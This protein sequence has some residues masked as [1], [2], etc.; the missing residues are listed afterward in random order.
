MA[1]YDLTKNIPSASSLKMGDIL[2]CPYSGTYQTLVL[3]KGVYIVE[4]WGA[5]GGSTSNGAGG[6]GAYKGGVLPLTQSSTTLYLYV[7]GAGTASSELGVQAGGWNGGGAGGYYYGGSGGGASDIRIN[8]TSLYAR[9]IVAGGGGGGCSYSSSYTGGYGGGSAAAGDGAGYSTTYNAKGAT[10]TAGGAG[11]SYNGGNYIGTAGSFG[12]GGAAATST[13]AN[14]GRSGGGGGG[15]YGG[16][17]GG[18]RAATTYYYG[19][20]GG[21]GGSSYAYNSSNASNY[22]SG[23]LLDSNYY[24]GQFYNAAGNVNIA[25]PDQSFSTGNEGNG[26]IRIIVLS[27]GGTRY[28]GTMPSTSSIK[29]GDIIEYYYNGSSKTVTLP[30]GIYKLECWGA[31]GGS[32]STYVGGKG[33]Y[34]S[35]ILTIMENTTLY[36]YAGGQG[37]R[38]TTASTAGGGGFNGG[39]DGATGT[40]TSYCGIGGGGASDIRAGTDSLY[41]RILV[42]GGGGGA[43]YYSTSFYGNGGVGGGNNGGNGTSNNTSSYLPGTG[44]TQIDGGLTY[45]ATTLQTAKGSFGTG[46]GWNSATAGNGGGG[47]WYGGGAATR[48]GGG[49]GSG[50]VYT[51]SNA[52]N[53]PSGC[54]LNNSY[55]LGSAINANGESIFR[56]YFGPIKQGH[57]EGGAVRITAIMVYTSVAIPTLTNATKTYNASAQSPT[58]NNYNTTYMTRTG[59]LSATMPGTYTVKYTLKEGCI[60]SDLTFEPKLLTWQ[61]TS[62]WKKAQSW[63]YDSSL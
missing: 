54:T 63:T 36:L 61:I 42:A 10:Q 23:C 17:G 8:S 50:Y 40:S 27:I 53:Y 2:N 25:G 14:Y 12:T 22:P 24:M 31:Q 19:Q 52:I 39:G 11:G 47:G 15:W 57:T 3:P 26:Y 46:V 49:G 35:G 20:S 58:E 32:Y 6:K 9:V 5:S 21:G 4:C 41:S 29:T 37:S 1:T 60:W 33:G 51:S 30:M 13:T 18:Y 16:G 48:V 34:A 45:S 44:G 43:G 7:G 59:E 55:Y 38:I 28:N 62:N 56:D